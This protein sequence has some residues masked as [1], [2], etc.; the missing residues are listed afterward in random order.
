MHGCLCVCVCVWVCVC[1]LVVPSWVFA[2]SE[3]AFVCLSVYACLCSY[4]FG[5]CLCVSERVFGCVCVCV[6]VFVPLRERCAV[7]LWVCVFVCVCG[8]W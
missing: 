1:G 8:V 3:Y 6:C 4:V 2:Q 7:C 5:V